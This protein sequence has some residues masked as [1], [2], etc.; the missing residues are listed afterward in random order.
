[1][2][3]DRILQFLMEDTASEVL[4]EK[5]KAY[6]DRLLLRLMTSPALMSFLEATQILKEGNDYIVELLFRKVP[7]EQVDVIKAFIAEPNTSFSF[8]QKGQTH[9]A[10]R[11]KLN[12]QDLGGSD[13]SEQGPTTGVPV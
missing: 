7:Q 8:E 5:A 6:M 11:V 4:D 12:P 1:M 10:F 13:D 3:I 2:T 9:F